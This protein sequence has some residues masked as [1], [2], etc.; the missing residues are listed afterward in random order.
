MEQAEI[1]KRSLKEL[2]KLF[3]MQEKNLNIALK[4]I[5]KDQQKK[6]RKIVSDAKKGKLSFSDIQNIKDDNYNKS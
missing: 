5:P 3:K 4:S 6:Y 1:F 2:E